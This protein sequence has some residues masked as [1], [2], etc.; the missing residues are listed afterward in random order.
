MCDG[1]VLVMNVCVG[2]TTTTTIYL[3]ISIYHHDTIHYECIGEMCT[4][5][6]KYY[7]TLTSVGYIH[8]RYTIIVQSRVDDGRGCTAKVCGM[9]FL[10][11]QWWV[12]H[13]VWTSERERERVDFCIVCDDGSYLYN[14]YI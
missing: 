1:N 8:R 6:S 7:Q 3:Y 11:H 5:S 4:P 2:T 12:Q 13:G 9:I 14:R 10:D